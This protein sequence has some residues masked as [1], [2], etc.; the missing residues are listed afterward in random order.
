M[1]STPPR[2][3]SL[4]LLLS[5]LLIGV[6][7][8]GDSDAAMGSAPSESSRDSGEVSSSPAIPSAPDTTSSE[9]PVE[10]SSTTSAVGPAPSTPSETP[11]RTGAGS[12]GSDTPP[13]SGG[14]LRIRS[15][16]PTSGPTTGS[17]PVTIRGEGFA[18][19]DEVFLGE[20]P[21]VDVDIVDEFIILA[22]TPAV[23]E[24]GVV[25]LRV[26]NAERSALLDG[27]FTYLA[28][29]ELLSLEP[30]RAS[31]GGGTPIR[32]RG[33]SIA[34]NSVVTFNG[35][36]AIET[37]WIDSETI[38]ATTP[39]LSPGSVTVRVTG[40]NGSA[41]LVGILRVDARPQLE[42]V[43]PGAGPAEGGNSLQL[44]GRGLADV[45]E[46][47]FR[48]ALATIVEQ[49]ET[50]MTVLA[51]AGSPGPARVTLTAPGGSSLTPDAYFYMGPS[52]GEG[53]RIA[54]V[55][56]GRGDVAGGDRVRVVGT[57]MALVTQVRFGGIQAPVI[58]DR[59]ETEVVV[60]TP[61]GSA[62]GPVSVEVRQGSFAPVLADA[63]TY[64]VRPRVTSVSPS[65]GD[66]AGGTPVAITGAALDGVD[67]VRFGPLQATI[68]SV[69]ATRVDVL[70]PP[71]SAGQ[72]EIVLRASSEEVRLPEAFTYTQERELFSLKPAR[73]AIAGNTWVELRGAGFLPDDPVFFGGSEVPESTW[74][75]P[76]TITVRTPPGPVGTAD[77]RVGEGAGA[78]VKQGAWTWFDPFLPGGG[79][80]G[81]A[82]DGAVNVTVLDAD[83]GARVPDAFVSLTI[84]DS[85]REL[86]A[87]TN[88]VGQATVSGPGLRGIQTVH[89]SAANYS[90]ATV[91]D[92]NAENIVVFLRYICTDPD[93]PRCD[94]DP[95]PPPPGPGFISGE[96]VGIDKIE[97]PGPGRRLIGAV[98]TT[99][100]NPRQ[101]GALPTPRPG[102][103]NVLV[104]DGRY[105]IASRLGSV[106]L[107]AV[108][109]IYDEAQGTF[110][111]RFIGISRG[112]TVL[113]N[114]QYEV[115]IDC[116][117]GL[118]RD[119]VVRVNDSPASALPAYTNII[120]PYFDFGSEGYFGG[121]WD[122]RG[123]ENTHTIRRLAPLTGQLA[124]LRYFVYAEAV[125]NAGLPYSAAVLS[126]ISE[127]GPGR[128]LQM[129]SF[130]PATQRVRPAL[131][132]TFDGR[133]LE[134]RSEGTFEPDFYF[135][136]IQDT[137][138]EV[139]F[140]EMWV[141]GDQTFV[142][143]PSF[144]PDAEVGP[145]PSGGEPFILLIFAIDALRFDYDAFQYNDFAITNWRSW[146]VNGW[147]IPTQ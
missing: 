63:F 38:E 29:T 8:C 55:I 50:E 144:P 23:A 114:E 100:P 68:Q 112:L 142:N 132:A 33:R 135:L 147:V 119:M 83:T 133:R 65:S 57:G 25:S 93:D 15:M 64:V 79:W 146:S 53:P 1:V 66:R 88:E 108:C 102:D 24:A 109:G 117:I 74:L 32:I 58:I 7:G 9:L 126:G 28:P 82:I 73:G 87:V 11:T 5:L 131:G 10:G 75:D 56:P 94:G 92:V 45:E 104:A 67:E 143:L 110:E 41:T 13:V 26:G 128:T 125:N 124:G 127:I 105:S 86:M 129:P 37:T 18:A 98:Y 59:S 89:V 123:R 76:T 137:M 31:E 84:R 43:F 69:S 19:D 70:T 115:D 99:F 17:T 72:V 141:P 145:F 80:W 121:L 103:A 118:A 2:M 101:A 22:R 42:G 122:V 113:S 40:D 139:D 52:E 12:S 136:L 14:E 106:A 44:R 96:L 120:A 140:W 91:Q 4:L 20:A 130:V 71:G 49:S 34:S 6:G 111:P 46:V 60:R 81:G 85:E 134:W 47:R 21:L 54:G 97:N 35:R 95:P 36:P 3:T 90:R 62:P 30:E 61:A 116:N 39:P 138:Q 51:P 77:V 107:V 48:S 78:A 27:A 16:S